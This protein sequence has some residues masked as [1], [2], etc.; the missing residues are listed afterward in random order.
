MISS[1]Y[2]Q[3]YACPC[4]A[5]MLCVS[6]LSFRDNMQFFFFVI[7]K[8]HFLD[9]MSN[10]ISLNFYVDDSNPKIDSD[11][12]SMHENIFYMN[13]IK[14]HIRSLRNKIESSYLWYDLCNQII[15]IKLTQYCKTNN[16]HCI[17]LRL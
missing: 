16:Y 7:H 6:E 8:N 17:I 12:L 15:Y 5:W 2:I 9:L 3:E 11:N 13:W 10:S 1:S 4:Q 14:N